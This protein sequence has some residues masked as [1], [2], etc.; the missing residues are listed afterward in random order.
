V[1]SFDAK[2]VVRIANAVR[3]VEGWVRK[4]S[5][6]LPNEFS[7]FSFVLLEDMVGDSAYAQIVLPDG[8]DE[9]VPIIKLYH[10]WN[11]LEGAV[12]GYEG[13][14]YPFK[15]HF[16]FLQG[17]CITK[18]ESSASITPGDPPEGEVN[19][20]YPGHTVS[21]T[22]IDSGSLTATGLPP[23]LSM[24]TSGVITGT[25]TEAG[26]FFAV[27]TGTA[28]KTGPGTVPAGTKCTLKA[29]LVITITPPGGGPVPFP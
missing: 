8:V 26:E 6:I 3:K 9:I 22:G 7:I 2:S 14:C 28:D 13:D 20:A 21:N 1:P 12:A 27:V 24:N 10:R 11:L 29:I 18:C 25:P 15:D 17:P 23:G 16:R 4:S 5:V 19:T